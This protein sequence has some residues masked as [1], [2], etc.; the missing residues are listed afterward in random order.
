MVSLV[1]LSHSEN[2]AK[3][4]MELAQE[5]AEGIPIFAAGG[6]GS[7]GLGSDYNLI[8]DTLEK[9][10]NPD[11]VVIFYDLGSSAMTAE[12]V[13]DEMDEDKKA[14]IK[15]LKAPLVEGAVA[16]AVEIKCGSGFGDVVELLEEM[17][18]IK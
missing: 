18:I 17:E 14:K 12:L 1:L 9:A 10:F 11:G 5:M 7:G 6:N 2:L 16:A 15:I 3:G 4:V 8:K 13:I